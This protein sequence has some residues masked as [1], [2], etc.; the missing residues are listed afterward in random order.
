MYRP[1]PKAA[2]K[3]IVAITTRRPRRET[4]AYVRFGSKAKKL[5]ASTSS[6]PNSRHPSALLARQLRANSGYAVYSIISL[7]S[8]S[9]V[10]GIPRSRAFAAYHLHADLFVPNK[11]P[12]DM[13][14]YD[15]SRAGRGRT[16]SPQD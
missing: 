5:A 7:A 6:G 10:G 8:A 15:L 14:K 11:S 4:G 3:A 12:S 1:R 9:S 16:H 13:T 2:L